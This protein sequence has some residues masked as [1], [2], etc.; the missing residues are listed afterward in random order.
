[1]ISRTL[2]GSTLHHIM[3]AVACGIGMND[4]DDLTT[5]TMLLSSPI[6]YHLLLDS[7]S[8]S[9]SCLSLLHP[10][11]LSSAWWLAMGLLLLSR[12]S[13]SRWCV[14]C[15]VAG[16]RVAVAGGT[17][18]VIVHGRHHLLLRLSF[19]CVCLIFVGGRGRK[20]KVCFKISVHR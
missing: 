12:E 17:S 9:L 10:L 6:I 2:D 5:T 11:A 1:M 8:S 7:V 16:G 20:Q 19:G 3:C 15:A 18:V 4:D 14:R 13:V